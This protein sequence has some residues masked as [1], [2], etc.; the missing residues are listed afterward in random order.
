AQ[1]AGRGEDTSVID[2]QPVP[3]SASRAGASRPV[4]PPRRTKRGPI[5]LAVVLVLAVLAGLAGWWFGAGRYETTP[6]VIN[7]TRAAAEEK[8]HAAGLGFEVTGSSYSETVPVGYVVSTDPGGGDRILRDGTVEALVSKGPERHDVP[9]VRGMTL[10]QAQDALQ[11][12][13]LVYG[14]ATYRFDARVAKGVVLASSPKAGTAL[15][16]GAAVDL[17]VSRGPRPIEIR[18]FTGKDADV[19]QRW[20]D[21]RGF[22]VDRSEENSD[23]V[24]AGRVISQTPHDGN[25]FKGDTVR[26]VVSKGPVLVEVPKVVGMGTQDAVSTLQGAGFQVDTQQADLYVGLQYVVRQSPG[27][28]EKAPRGSTITIQIV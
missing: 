24:A 7:M 16:R 13:R 2:R 20:F 26:L 5:L 28:G 22:E 14:H 10:D 18:D 1:A 12:S 6:G 23:T 11:R 9:A 27:A 3:L 21:R 15:K 19:A 25:G 4:P 17:V 8:V